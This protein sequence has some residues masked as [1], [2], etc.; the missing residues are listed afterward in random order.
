METDESLKHNPTALWKLA[1]SAPAYLICNLTAGKKNVALSI[2]QDTS[3][4]KKETSG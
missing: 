4:P 3:E 1:D 2:R